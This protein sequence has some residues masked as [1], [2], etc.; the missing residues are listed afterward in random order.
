MQFF[1]ESHSGVPKIA[2]MRKSL[3]LLDKL[4]KKFKLLIYVIG[5]LFN[6]SLFFCLKI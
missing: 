3:K 6:K 4:I 5:N 2:D 1:K